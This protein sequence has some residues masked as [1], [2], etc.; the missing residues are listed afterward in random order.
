MYIF[1]NS[2]ASIYELVI[3]REYREVIAES[4]RKAIPKS[5]SI[6]LRQSIEYMDKYTPAVL[7]A[8]LFA[9]LRRLALALVHFR[10]T[11]RYRYSSDFKYFLNLI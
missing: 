9:S 7:F 5:V 1:N 11:R 6:L 10:T 2:D 3:H 8:M 4:N